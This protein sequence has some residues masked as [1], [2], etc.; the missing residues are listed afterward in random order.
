[1]S[2]PPSLQPDLIEMKARMA[3]L[4]ARD[5]AKEAGVPEASVPK[6]PTNAPLPLGWSAPVSY[7]PAPL[8]VTFVSGSS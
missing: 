5:E 4:A 6:F 7:T 1:M 8:G 2:L 3:L